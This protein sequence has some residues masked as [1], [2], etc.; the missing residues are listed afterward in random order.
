[1]PGVLWSRIRNYLYDKDFLPVTSAGS[2][3][4]SIGNLTW[5]GTGKTPMTASI[6]SHFL[7]K[8]YRVAIISRGFKRQSKGLRL[9][10]DGKKLLETD[11]QQAG[12][13]PFWL[14]SRIPR[15]IVVVSEKRKQALDFLSTY[16]PHLIL[17]DDG[18]Q[19][20]K[21]FRNFDLVLVDSS[22]NLLK[23]KVLP[24]GKLR[25]P[26]DS[27]K[28]ADAIILTQAKESNA[29]T[30]KWIDENISAPVFHA[31]YEAH[32]ADVFAGKKVA[33]FCGIGAPR[34]FFQLIEEDGGLLFW[35][36]K[37]PDHHYYTRDD[38]LRVES[39][40]IIAGAE[41]L[42]TTEKDWVKFRD[43]RFRLP[44]VPVKAELKIVEQSDLF[45][46]IE[47]RIARSS[48]AEN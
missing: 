1:M 14:A 22:E 9:V 24:F 21:V 43:F 46:L 17:M 42:L 13:E 25:E 45:D 30:L 6:A 40:A 32:N 31:N 48:F 38:L 18:F 44:L 11:W 7:S 15:A 34:H 26:V 2:F 20:R 47:D 29:R 3:V 35:K 37:F 4:L 28:R 27:L 8:S 39:E 41:L 23:Q 12:E 19:H 10:S 16:N 33:A 5:G 36:K